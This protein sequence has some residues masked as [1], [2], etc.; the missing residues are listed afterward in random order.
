ML[1]HER[2][3]HGADTQHIYRHL[4]RCRY[5][6]QTFFFISDKDSV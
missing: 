6:T 1:G 2:A 4:S 3:H 5:T